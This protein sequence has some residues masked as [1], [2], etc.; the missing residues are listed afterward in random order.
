MEY[1]DIEVVKKADRSAGHYWF[2]PDAMRFFKSRVAQT[3][4]K[5]G[6]KAYF[7]SSEQFETC[8]GPRR[9]RLYSIRVCDL[10]TG[11]IGTY[12]D[13]D[14]FQKYKTGEQAMTDLKR[15]LT[16]LEANACKEPGPK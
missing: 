11:D 1:I 16:E 7:V 8:S 10:K 9:P 2:E 3:A 6:N 4:L 13:H 14:G 12:P 15:I 5:V